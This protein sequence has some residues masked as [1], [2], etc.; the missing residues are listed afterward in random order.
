MSMNATSQRQG[1]ESGWH[2]IA[3]GFLKLVGANGKPNT[4]KKVRLQLYQPLVRF[5]ARP[6]QLEVRVFVS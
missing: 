6:D 5:R 4:D 2:R 3:W 1:S